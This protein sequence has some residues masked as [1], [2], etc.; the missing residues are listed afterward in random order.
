MVGQGE[1]MPGW[2]YE[3]GLLGRLMLGSPL[4]PLKTMQASFL[5]A[6]A[7]SSGISSSSWRGE[8]FTDELLTKPLVDADRLNIWRVRFVYPILFR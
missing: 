2:Q 6:A 3:D 1:A 7:A 5:E 8:F 4:R